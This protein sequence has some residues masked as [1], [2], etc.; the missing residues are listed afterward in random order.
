M[1]QPFPVY[2]DGQVLPEEEA[3]ISPQDQGFL[4]G[5]SVFDT[6]L[7]QDETL[8]FVDEHLARLRRGV[9]SLALEWPPPYDPK[10][11]LRAMAEAIG[12]R[13]A[14]LRITVTRG[15]PG[16]GPTV[17][18]TAKALTPP[19]EEGVRVW[20]TSYQKL[21]SAPLEA[22]KTTNRL[23]NVLAW[24]EA[25]ANDCWEA[26]FEN[27]EGDLTEGTI[28][29]LFLVRDGVLITAAI[30][31]GCLSGIVRERIL[32]S[33]ELEPMEIDGVQLEVRVGRVRHEDL[34]GASEVLLTNTTGR[35]IPVVDVIGQGLSITG[36]PAA[37]GPVTRAL[38]IRFRA[39]EAAYRLLNAKS[40]SSGAT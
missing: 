25:R 27:H 13:E 35:I 18:V 16:R 2:V 7:W 21:G 6:L 34:E 3:R 5:L 33:L 4:L 32:S 1:S 15:V 26:L 31:Q 30:D 12:P 23:R 22:I 17:V 11:A 10:E 36:L 37:M 38:K 19:P 9:E 40:A 28:S 20:L 39:L 29:N 14:A 8:Y 24:E